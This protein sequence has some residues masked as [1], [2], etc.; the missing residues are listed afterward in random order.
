[1]STGVG[2][3]LELVRHGTDAVRVLIVDDE[4]LIRWAL[5][6]ALGAH[7]CVVT[8]AATARE[9][10]AAVRAHDFDVVV[11]D[12]RLPDTTHLELLRE[13]RALS[14]ASHVVM[15]TAFGTPETLNEAMELG[16][17]R[18]LEK[19]IDLDVATRAILDI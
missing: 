4:M 16:V 18:V 1:M 9:A 15:M 6:Q 7:R 5:G 3:D 19:P 10:L 14:P 17:S 2:G 13:V 12:Y 11:M 8:E